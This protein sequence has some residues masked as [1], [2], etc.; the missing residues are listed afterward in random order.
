MNHS[1]HKTLMTT[2]GE[3]D[4]H[5]KSQGIEVIRKYCILTSVAVALGKCPQAGYCKYSSSAY[6][7]E[8]HSTKMPAGRS[9]S[10]LL[11]VQ[12]ATHVSGIIFQEK[13]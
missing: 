11:A 2:L 8:F 6:G 5:L 1:G 9:Q 10:L 7:N 3:W 13:C 4:R 12:V